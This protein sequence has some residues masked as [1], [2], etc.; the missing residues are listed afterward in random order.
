[1]GRA[2]CAPSAIRWRAS[3]KTAAVL[4]AARFAATLECTIEDDHG[5]HLAQSRHL[6]QVS[7]ERIRDEW[8][9]TMV[10]KK[11]SRAFEVMRSTGILEVTL[12]ELL[13]SVGCEQ[14]RHHAYDVWMHSMCA[15]TR[16][17][18]DPPLRSRAAADLESRGRARA[19]RKPGILPSTKHETVGAE[20]AR[21]ALTR[22]RFSTTMRA[23]HPARAK[24]SRLLFRRV[25]D[26]AVR[27]FLRR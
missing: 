8:V 20:M 19:A 2:F 6:P 24:S 7:A 3:R 22:L 5:R 1:L 15:S 23:H 21:A 27:K 14:N 4:R 26:A 25:T 10:A 11:P 18:G 17:E 16:C 12:P 9:K 13:E